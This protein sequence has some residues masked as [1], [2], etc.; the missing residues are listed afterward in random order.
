MRSFTNRPGAWDSLRFDRTLSERKWEVLGYSMGFLIIG[1]IAALLGSS[2]A[3]GMAAP[4]AWI[5][6]PGFLILSIL[7]LASSRRTLL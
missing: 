3:A 6:S 2:G 5:L 7:G 4:I 1:G